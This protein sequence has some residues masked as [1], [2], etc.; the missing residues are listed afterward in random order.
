VTKP[1]RV[2][3]SPK[4]WQNRLPFAPAMRVPVAEWV[5]LSGQTGRDSDGV[6]PQG[7]GMAD[8]AKRAFENIRDLLDAAGSSLESVV[9]LTYYVTEM[10]LWQSVADA[11]DSFFPGDKPA[12]T[13]VEVSRLHDPAALI[14]ID[15]IAIATDAT[16]HEVLMSA[17]T[18]G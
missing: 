1:A 14:E 9:K 3:P 8:Q 7:S 6:I 11:R 15:A 5:I 17:T 13:T 2:V 16:T 18:G 10:S 12:S 4:P